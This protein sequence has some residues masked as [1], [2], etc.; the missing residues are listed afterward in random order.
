MKSSQYAALVIDDC[1]ASTS[2]LR[3]LL[4]VHGAAAVEVNGAD[5]ARRMLGRFEFDVLVIDYLMDP[6]VN[7]LDFLRWCRAQ[8]VTTPALICSG[9]EPETLDKVAGAIAAEG[10]GPARVAGKPVDPPELVAEIEA[11]ALAGRKG[12]S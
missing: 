5:E 3:M 8:G 1:R 7:G 4:Y 11:L 10:L 2:S 12:D 9:V 6:K